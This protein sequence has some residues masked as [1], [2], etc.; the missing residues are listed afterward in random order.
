M[1]FLTPLLFVALA[2]LAIPV[3]LHLTER[4]RKQVV[5]FPSLMFLRKI[6]YRSVRR[7]RIQHW[8]LL[9]LRLLALLAIVTAFTR[10][11]LGSATLASAADGGARELVVLLDRSASM[12]FGD[13]DDRAKQAARDAV[14]GLRAE[15]RA[16]LVFFSTEASVEVRSSP[17][18][19]AWAAAVDRSR[20]G[21][22]G[23]RYGP[24]LRA[25]QTILAESKLPQREVV[26]ISD[27]QKLGWD[28]TDSIRLPERTR[29]TPVA[30]STPEPANLSVTSVS[31]E[32]STFA[33]QE[34]VVATAAITNR[35]LL[36]LKDVDASLEID[37]RAVQTLKVNIEGG[38]STALAF[39]P[40]TLARALT[41][42]T[43]RLATDS[44]VVDNTLNFVIRPATPVP[45]ALVEGNTGTG[46]RTSYLQQALGIG[47]APAFAVERKASGAFTQGEMPRVAI[48][49]DVAID[50]GTLGDIE[51]FASAGGGV[52]LV[53]GERAQWPAAPTVLPGTLGPPVDRVPS[54]GAILGGLEYGHAIFDVFAAPRSGD[55]SLAR[56]FRYRGLTLNEGGSILARF[57]DG[58]PALAERRVGT[59]RILVWSSTFDTIWSDLPLQPVF[60]PFVHRM[61]TYLAQYHEP[62]GWSTVGQLARN[63]EFTRQVGRTSS[64]AA[65]ERSGAIRVL[66]P[67]GA[68]LDVPAA[69][70]PNGAVVSLEEP[71]F[72][73]LLSGPNRDPNAPTVAVNMDPAESDLSAFDPQELVTM[74]TSAPDATQGAASPATT[75][76][77]EERERRQGLWWYLLLFGLMLLGVESVVSSRFAVR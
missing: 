68:T 33:G 58:S 44:L 23:T 74:V 15:D 8:S 76:S 47:R 45:V 54:R 43:V 42:G 59:G 61:A 18:R 16:S 38:T 72:Y 34:R 9:A 6:P 11:F 27:F 51:R 25:A 10:P 64:S 7:R 56:F 31:F 40:V 69:T 66:T 1:S 19:A 71:G 57:D 55:F 73:E 21:A 52:L 62:A 20:A 4:E 26:M 30:I 46:T 24:A 5:E 36:G 32:R 67:A 60:L 37:G 14:S 65:T 70:T 29:V 13:H 3:L 28:R 49:N 17:D 53:A 39:A 12:G 2:G 50:T 41:R 77:L 75:L 48:F 22:G 35:G 63:E